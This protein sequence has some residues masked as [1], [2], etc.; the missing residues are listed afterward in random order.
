MKNTDMVENKVVL[1]P[2]QQDIVEKTCE[3]LRGAPRF[4][5]LSMEVRTGKTLTALSALDSVGNISTVLFVTK[6]K[7]IGGIQKDYKALAPSYSCDFINYESLHKVVETCYDAIVFDEAH[8]MG[9]FPKPSLR[10]IEARRLIQHC[11]PYVIFLSGTPSPESYSQ[12]YHQMWILGYR[13]PF[14]EPTFYKWAHTYVKIWER[15]INGFRVHDYSN[16]IQEKIMAEVKPYMISYTQNEAGFTSKVNE[17]VLKVTMSDTTYKIA[18]KLKRDLVFEGKE[19]V[20]LADTPVKLMQ[21]LHQIYS[22]TVILES[23]K[24]IILDKTKAE[25]IR[26]KFAGKRIAV[27]YKF[28]AE[29]ECLL[30]VFQEDMTTDL[31]KFHAGECNNFAI[32]IVTGREGI[33]LKEADFLVY[34]NI[35][36]SATSYW[37]SRDRLTTMDRL[38]NNVYWIFAEGGIEEKIY[39]V[40]QGKKNFTLQ[41]FKKVFLSL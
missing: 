13:S 6:K 25:F 2:Y 22:G 14:T 41:H 26:E 37:Q 35:D 38:E 40:V 30:S 32:Q 36:F 24:A 10:A 8:G 39:K 21:K 28:Q 4:A 31:G 34:F 16:G 18:D 29:L 17:H 3:L 11:D 1:R 9:A 19:D 20:I 15:M 12:M 33:S 7:A 5:Y 23:G 27:F